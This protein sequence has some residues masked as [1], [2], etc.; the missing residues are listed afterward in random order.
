MEQIC[1]VVEGRSDK[2]QLEKIVANNVHIICTN[3]TKDEEALIEL[4]EPYED[5][6]LFTFFDRDKSGD[7][8]RKKMQRVYSEA[9]QLQIPAPYIEVAE[10]PIAILRTILSA[11]KIDVK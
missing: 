9:I 6:M 5:A 3:G 7:Y 11:A 8:L 1:L 10:T 2:Q 4:I